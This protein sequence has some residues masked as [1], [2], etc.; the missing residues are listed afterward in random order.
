MNSDDNISE[1]SSDKEDGKD[2]LSKKQL[3]TLF[4]SI[5]N[6]NKLGKNK[7]KKGKMKN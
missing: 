6:N 7:F 2:D 3:E 1:G 4:S 5:K